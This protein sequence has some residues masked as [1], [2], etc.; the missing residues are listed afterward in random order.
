MSAY[1]RR[2]PGTIKEATSELVDA[3]G[4]QVKA[5]EIS[6]WRRSYITDYTDESERHASRTMPVGLVRTLEAVVGKPILSR[7]LVQELGW[8]VLPIPE[9]ATSGRLGQD[10]AAIAQRFAELMAEIGRASCLAG[11]G[12]A[13]VTPA[14]AGRLIAELDDLLGPVGAM[15]G[16]LTGV[17]DGE[18]R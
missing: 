4:G 12:G 18:G 14:E 9:V 6:G 2:T 5:A 17:R 7:F 16:W 8:I 15:R 13:R 1:K 3:V 10:T 11:A